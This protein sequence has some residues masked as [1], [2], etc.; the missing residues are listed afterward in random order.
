MA[1]IIRYENTGVSGHCTRE[2]SSFSHGYKI[3][4]SICFFV[5]FP[6]YRRILEKTHVKAETE[7]QIVSFRFNVIYIACLFHTKFLGR[8]VNDSTI[9]RTA[10]APR[11]LSVVPFLLSSFHLF[12][13]YGYSHVGVDKTIHNGLYLSILQ[14]TNLLIAFCLATVFQF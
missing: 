14:S 5:G 12:K 11:H 9:W 3:V 13:Y 4:P 10:I 2:G 1:E 7:S 6:A 8:Q